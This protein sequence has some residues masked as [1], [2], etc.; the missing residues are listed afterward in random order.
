MSRT[1]KTCTLMDQ[2]LGYSLFIDHH[3]A[4]DSMLAVCPKDAPPSAIFSR[5]E[6]VA[7]YLF[8]QRPDVGALMLHVCHEHFRAQSPTLREIMDGIVKVMP[9]PPMPPT[10][11][12]PRRADGDEAPSQAA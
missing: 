8:F 1:R 6:L 7:L 2:H 5:A 10:Q 9:L 12:P 11:W 4:R 3:G